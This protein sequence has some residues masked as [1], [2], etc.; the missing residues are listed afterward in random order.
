MRWLVINPLDMYMYHAS[1]RAATCCLGIPGDRVLAAVVHPSPRV[2]RRVRTL[3]QLLE[4]RK[5]QD[6]RRVQSSEFILVK[7]D[8]LTRKALATD[9]GEY[10]PSARGRLSCLRD[11]GER[12]DR[13]LRYGEPGGVTN[14]HHQPGGVKPD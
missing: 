5:E 2:T 14:R 11:A 9:D 3:C 1:S 12:R 7:N 13:A 6:T 10:R 4:L 8:K